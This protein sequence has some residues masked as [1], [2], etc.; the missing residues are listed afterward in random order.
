MEVMAEWA[1]EATAKVVEA[2]GRAAKVAVAVVKEEM[3]GLVRMAV[4]EAVAEGV[5]DWRKAHTPSQSMHTVQ[6][7]RP[8]D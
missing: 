7:N 2:M 6:R 8:T 1:K 4:V 3:A 5:P